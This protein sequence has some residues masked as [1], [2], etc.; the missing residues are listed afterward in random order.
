MSKG[1]PLFN[2]I[3]LLLLMPKNNNFCNS[4]KKSDKVATRHMLPKKVVTSREAVSIENRVLLICSNK[5]TSRETHIQCKTRQPQCPF[6]SIC[7]VHTTR[8]MAVL[9]TWT[10]YLPLREIVRLTILW[11]IVSHWDSNK[12]FLIV[13]CNNYKIR[14]I[15]ESGPPVTIDLHLASTFPMKWLLRIK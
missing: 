5:F 13:T 12:G 2:W 6:I 14:T 1:S 4:R 3:K 15:W 7:K 11:A 9:P 8:K 10:V